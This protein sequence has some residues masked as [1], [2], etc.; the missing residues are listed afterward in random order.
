MDSIH[1]IL[2]KNQW[3]YHVRLITHFE[4]WLKTIQSFQDEKLTFGRLMIL[5][6]FTT[7]VI[8]NLQ[9]CELLNAD[10]SAIKE[11]EKIK[12]YYSLHFISER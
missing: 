9:V 6:I 11:S 12:Y 1:T 10:D 7:S 2:E 4:P 5:H 8:K 3:R